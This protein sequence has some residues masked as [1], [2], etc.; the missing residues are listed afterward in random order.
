MGGLIG[1]LGWGVGVGDGEGDGAVGW[2]GG[3][4]SADTQFRLSAVKW[5]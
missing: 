4:R 1:G 3:A 2:G 5:C